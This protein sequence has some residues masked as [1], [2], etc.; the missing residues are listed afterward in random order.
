MNRDVL[1]MARDKTEDAETHTFV[2]RSIAGER[3]ISNRVLWIMV[4]AD[5]AYCDSS[6]STTEVTA[7]Y[8]LAS[9]R[10]EQEMRPRRY[11]MWSVVLGLQEE[12]SLKDVAK[13]EEEGDDEG[14]ERESLGE[15]K[16]SVRRWEHRS[17]PTPTPLRVNMYGVIYI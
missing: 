12:N 13:Q 3:E 2:L 1:N 15:H 17:D 9:S 14:I 11:G 10:R 4:D 16:E 7:E 6:P 8:V 5:L